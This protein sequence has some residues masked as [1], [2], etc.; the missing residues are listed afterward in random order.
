M[1]STE[2]A[3]NISKAGGYNIFRLG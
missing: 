1:K 2:K 3:W